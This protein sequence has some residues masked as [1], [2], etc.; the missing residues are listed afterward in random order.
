MQAPRHQGKHKGA[1]FVK[2]I[3][4]DMVFGGIEHHMS[5]ML[6]GVGEINPD[7]STALIMN[8]I[9]GGIAAQTSVASEPMAAVAM[10]MILT[11]EP[12]DGLRAWQLG[13]VSRMAP[14]SKLMELALATA[15]TIAG[16]APGAVRDSLSIARLS[17][18]AGEERAWQETSEAELRRLASDEVTEGVQAFIEKR[19]PNWR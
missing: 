15:Q 19:L 9:F 13:L 5:G 1:A 8:T 10:D 12:I 11:G 4:R 3:L 17:L 6:F 18:E 7:E 2:S 16:H 14:S